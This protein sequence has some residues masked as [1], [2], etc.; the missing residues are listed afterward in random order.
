M[1]EL[2]INGKTLDTQD[3]KIRYVKQVN[4]LADVTTV[5]TSYSYYL[6]IPKTP[7]NTSILQGLGISGDTSNIPYEKNTT[8]L[9]DNGSVIIANG[10]STI[11]ETSDDYKIVVQDGIIDFFRSIENKTIGKDLDL[12]EI[13][14]I[15]NTASIIDSFTNPNYRY[16]LAEYNGETKKNNAINPDYQVPSVNQK[17]IWDKIMSYSGY[18]YSNLPEIGNEWITF[19]IPP[20]I[21]VEEEEQRFLA[22]MLNKSY[23][24]GLNQ[25][26]RNN[27]PMAWDNIF[28][29][30]TDFTQVLNG[31]KLKILQTANYRIESQVLGTMKYLYYETEYLGFPPR[32]IEVPK[33]MD[34]PIIFDIF[35]NGSNIGTFVNIEDFDISSIA[36]SESD[37]ISLFPREVTRQEAENWF[38]ID[39]E[40]FLDQLERGEAFVYEINITSLVFRLY[41]LGI[42][43]FDFG[44]ALKDYSMT[45]FVKEIMFRKSLTPFPDINEKHITFQTLS[46]R[47]DTT[48]SIDWSSNFGRR[49]KEEYR[50]GDYGKQNILKL[51]HDNEDDSFG[52]GLLAVNNENLKDK[53]VILQS[54][55]Y[56]PSGIL[57]K[58]VGNE[59]FLELKFWE[60]EIKEEDDIKIIEYKPLNNRFFLLREEV[61]DKSIKIGEV[62]VDSYPKASMNGTLLSD[63]VDEYYKDWGKVFN[64]VRLHDI[65]LTINAYDIATLRLDV[66]YYFEQE[67]SFY[68]LNRMPYETGKTVIGE[69]IKINI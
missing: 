14:H 66:P 43:V 4:D 29:Y 53:E 13:I 62:T 38:E 50:I 12:S 55:Y 49:L 16:L 8:Q 17:Y 15:R 64:S 22:N 35:K 6:N 44:E 21:S 31:L 2:I 48:K 61:V 39:N 40:Q 52:D 36:L 68:L 41:S 11:K 60:R 63:V 42:E 54:K 58:I 57:R 20:I 26:W 65:E 56:A 28:V 5:N 32:P 37:I 69:F 67:G 45:D 7:N 23:T 25:D 18:T 34:L 30:D 10:V 46:Q 59:F 9:M 27:I 3:P 33:S 1:V 19:P 24:Y 47:L 51:R